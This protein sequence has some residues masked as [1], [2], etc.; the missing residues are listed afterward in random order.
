MPDFLEGGLPP[1]AQAQFEHHLVGCAA[2]QA[3]SETALQMWAL[4]EELA[5]RSD[6]PRAVAPPRRARRWP[7]GAAAVALAAVVALVVLRRD[8]ALDLDRRVAAELGPHRTTME[9][10]PYAA[11][12]RYRDHEVMRAGPSQGGAVPA[13]IGLRPAAGS[14]PGEPI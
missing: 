7:V 5:Q 13:E 11:L 6:R 8:P 9:R 1:D 14:A 2:C 3:A 10:L 4:G 12:D